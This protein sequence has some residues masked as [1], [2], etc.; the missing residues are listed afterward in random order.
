MLIFGNEK[1]REF[2][3]K[4]AEHY[5]VSDGILFHFDSVLTKTLK[6]YSKVT[7]RTYPYTVNI[8]K[9]LKSLQ[10]G[11]FEPA[12]SFEIKEPILDSNGN[13]IWYGD[14]RKGFPLRF[15]YR[16][17]DSTLLSEIG[18]FETNIHGVLAGKT[19]MGKSNTVNVLLATLM[20]EY[21]P[22]ELQIYLLDA[23]VVEFKPFADKFASPHIKAVAATEDSE[24]MLSLLES[25]AEEMNTLNSFF[26]KANQS[27][28][29]ADFRDNT[30]L[31]LPQTLIV[32]DEFE[33]AMQDKKNVERFIKVITRFA[34][35]GRNTGYHLLL[36][37]QNLDSNINQSLLDQLKIRMALPVSRTM[38]EK[39]LNNVG[40]SRI[41]ERGELLVNTEP[42][43]EEGGLNN[44]SYFRTPYIPSSSLERVTSDC[45]RIAEGFGVNTLI[46]SYNDKDIITEEEFL[47]KIKNIPIRNDNN[48]SDMDIRFYL[49]EP[50]FIYPDSYKLFNIRFTD[51]DFESVLISAGSNINLERH[52]K[53]IKFNLERL[54]KLY[55]KNR[56]TVNF[57]Y[58][59]YFYENIGFQDLCAPGKYTNVD[60]V[61]SEMFQGFIFNVYFRLLV[62]NADKHAFRVVRTDDTSEKIFTKILEEGTN[63]E[64]T[65]INR[66]RCYY[67]MRELQD[68]E[69]YKQLKVTKVN[70]D[71]PR[72]VYI[73]KNSLIFY[74]AQ[75]CGDIQLTMQ[76]LPVQFNILAG[77]N[78][79]LGLGI[80][81]KPRNIEMLKNAM[82]YSKDVRIK[83]ILITK[84]MDDLKELTSMAG[85]T[86]V[87]QV[88]INQMTKAGLLDP[89]SSILPGLCLFQTLSEKKILKYKKFTLMSELN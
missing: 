16:D 28:N 72:T 46:S 15:G 77:I 22:W 39:L 41:F 45:K 12:F 26:D 81:T 58:S 76:K 1:V 40:A 85:Y 19:G 59:E 66:V 27:K 56:V 61:N 50:A 14:S 13:P 73:I 83:I 75:G 63:I 82:I 52:T 31:S 48:S 36:A 4:A 44:N 86:I 8:P 32:F 6:T 10:R 37:S 67:L 62:L 74:N 57:A 84:R 80:D 43:D 3:L 42:D 33:T 68:T 51:R 23:K 71:D 25:V 79:I 38:S 47:E 55:G 87:D 29:I 30:G 70:A 69:K 64:D 49:G 7:A 18:Y 65:K 89:P 9:N 11:D 21:A 24:Y 35:L 78:N 54:Q 34:K 53:C 5:K 60:N 17:N 2:V 88:D 20:S